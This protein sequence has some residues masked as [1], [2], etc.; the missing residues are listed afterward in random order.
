MAPDGPSPAGEDGGPDA[1][2]NAPAPGFFAEL[3][4]A[5]ARHRPQGSLTWN[6]SAMLGLLQKAFPGTRD[7]RSPPPAA[8]AHRAGSL[9]RLRRAKDAPGGAVASSWSPGEDIPEAAGGG[10]ARYEA[11]LRTTLDALIYLSARVDELET[12]RRRRDEP[13]DAP[14][15]LVPA[16]DASPWGPAIVAELG[17]GPVLHA[18]CGEGG[19][20]DALAAAGLS[21]RGVE[22][23]GDLAW[24][25]AR[26]GHEVTVG[27]P[28]E[29]LG[30]VAGG[31][32]G[33]LVLSG[34]IDRA[35]LASLVALIERA[36][37]VLEPGATLVVV[38]AGPDAVLPPGAR[39]LS[40]GRPL[41]AETWGVL[42]ERAGFDAVAPL[43]GGE[44][45]PGFALRARTAR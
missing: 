1:R 17:K 12:E 37:V 6:L 28:L 10:E 33:A 5:F 13:V 4:D 30:A 32:L 19:L 16:F 24:E 22:P 9:A 34:V 23:R 25:A 20:L 18:E 14:A 21:A 8:P 7:D 11:A 15:Q 42:L 35:P 40:P 27:D 39:D 2:A 38:G 3:T 31:S 36:A 44:P 45:R 29:R 26:R 41:H 43:V